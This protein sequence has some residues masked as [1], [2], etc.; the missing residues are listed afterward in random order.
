LATPDRWERTVGFVANI[1]EMFPDNPFTTGPE[2]VANGLV[3]LA[4]HASGDIP[5]L[6]AMDAEGDPVSQL[7]APPGPPQNAYSALVA[8]YHPTGNVLNRLL[9]AGVDQFFG[10]A[11][12][13]VVPS[14][15]GWQVDRSDAMFVPAS[16]IGCYGPG[17]NLPGDS[18][19]HLDFFQ[20]PETADFLV[21][22]LAGRQQPLNAVDPRK[23][24]P[25]RVLL[26]GAVA[27]TAPV[28]PTVAV[29]GRQRVSPP[30]P[31]EPPLHVTVVNGDLSFESAPLL[32]GHYAA[33]LLTGTE[34]VM[35]RL[36]GGAMGRALKA[37]LYPLEPGSHQIFINQH[38][39]AE[40]GILIP[41]PEAVIVA[42]LG[43]EG[44]L[45]PGDLVTTVRLAV[46]GWA[47]R[48]TEPRKRRRAVTS[49]ELASTLIGSGGT[50]ISAGKAADLI[51][52][53]VQEANDLLLRDRAENLTPW[54][55]CSHLRLTELYLDRATEGWSAI[56]MREETAPQRLKLT[57]IVDIRPGAMPRPAD[58]GYRGADYDL[59]TVQTRRAE[60]G[61]CILEYTLDT[62]RA[63]SE[64]RGQRAQS[65][66]LKDLIATA[67]SDRNRD[68]RI[69]RTVF[70]LVIPIELESYLTASG[71]MQMS[72]DTTTAAIPWELLDVT[73]GETAA[74]EPW[75]IR[76]KLLRK[77]RIEQFRETEQ[78]LDA[79]ADDGILIIGEPQC[80]PEYPRLDAAREE[81]LVVRDCLTGTG[82][83]P[84]A[85]VKLLA[86]ENPSGQGPDAGEVI[87][88]MFERRWRIVHISGHGELGKHNRPSGVV[89]SGSLCLSSSEIQ[90]MRIVPQLVFVNCCYL[91]RLAPE[92]TP[93]L[94]RAR[95]ASSVAGALIKIGVRC[96]VA[97]GWAVEDEAAKVFA[98]GFYTSLLRGSRFIDAVA[99]GRR[100][101]FQ[102]APGG[103]TWAAY[104]CYGDPNWKFDPNVPDPN[105]AEPT[106]ADRE[107]FASAFALQLELKRI[108]VETEFQE[109]DPVTQA[110][111]LLKLEE[112]LQP[113][114][115]KDGAVAEA[116][117]GA[118]FAAGAMENALRWY[119]RA[120]EA[121]DGRA[122]MAATEQLS[123]ARCRLAWENVDKAMRQRDLMA[124]QVATLKQT[125]NSTQKARAA[126]ARALRDA[127]KTQRAAA[128]AADPMVEES[129]KLLS[130]IIQVKS[131]MERENLVGS[132]FKRSALI[133]MV[134]G[135]TEQARSD[136]RK[137]KKAYLQA[138]KV[139]KQ[140][141]SDR[142]FYPA[143]NC[144][145]ADLALAAGKKVRL[146]A[147]L[148][149]IVMEYLSKKQ[150][151]K[152]D[153]WS[154]AAEIE[155]DEY[156][157]LAAGQLSQHLRKLESKFWELHKRAK[158]RRMWAS[159]YDNACLVLGSY[160]KGSDKK[161]A[162]A[163][164]TLLTLLRTFAHPDE[165]L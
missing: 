74:G 93:R 164:E 45:Q 81:A 134:A 65:R 138:L 61:E 36:V 84:A 71:D 16:R 13:L 148:R 8:N 46:I 94:D 118:Y 135:R 95:F 103:N 77:L 12:D 30:L 156:K 119:Q 105:Q 73:R 82:G 131:T 42:G 48:L 54:P 17:G 88:S 43:A 50:G 161:G 27:P 116:F 120:V 79:T 110:N 10:S 154:V 139:G 155:L 157:C 28:R 126:A 108:S 99:E 80:P 149:N 91:A 35:D 100:A 106:A 147:N 104:Q 89:L 140:E 141:G 130:R 85:R 121:T 129:L 25:D 56:R 18:V 33:T 63:R 165:T 136:L 113:D 68:E 125:K 21:N 109:R 5:G 20:Q 23:R 11:N 59:I 72:L 66:L 158:P 47:R 102:R 97:A 163:A 127:E 115:A 152:A 22:A 24:L 90:S 53:G 124:R 151:D 40:R 132:V 101:A 128:V 39:D 142:L 133:N 143:S 29:A 9:D 14:E 114:W 49:F 69:G 2:F 92:Q 26:R 70:N 55:H 52:R 19:T 6:H 15:G 38:A 144:L 160:A 75:A 76:T 78:V 87:N 123:N 32:L 159:V 86:S 7:Q 107:H 117:G 60:G 111:R 137:M 3:W 58:W 67:S 162:A 83:L 31:A 122:S 57:K 98:E 4:N 41:R 44:K 64:V 51:V 112:S 62:R 1:L 96:V 145:A 34:A 37:G 146:D 153:F 150:G